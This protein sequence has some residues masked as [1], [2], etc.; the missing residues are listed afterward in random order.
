M[1]WY[2][3][4]PYV[5]VATRRRNAEKEAAKLSKKGAPLEPIRDVS[6]KIAES[7]WGQSWCKNLEAYSDFANRLPRGRTY[8]RNDSV[9]DLKISEGKIT[10]MVS[11]SELYKITISIDALSSSQWKDVKSRC[12][13]QIGS[14][15]E[16]LQGKLSK[17]VMEVVTDKQNGLFPKPKE[18]RMEC[19]CPDYAGMCKH[20]AATMY[21][22]ACR[23]DQ[24][25]E[26]LFLLRKVDHGELIDQAI[27]TAPIA[28][29]TKAK[30]LAKADLADVFG[31]DL[32]DE[33]DGPAIAVAVAEPKVRKKAAAVKV[34]AIEE[35]AAKADKPKRPLPK[36]G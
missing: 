20:I 10:S 28:T 25:P 12:V 27:P 4:K 11:G 6:R 30:K 26:L 36:K 24:K 32:S 5:P 13:G 21:G 33:G 8:V 9:I 15:I 3:F 17:G 31:I 23:L 34:K 29:D 22:V 2:Q 7:F 35:P 1:S 18:I 19:S 16:L 14:L